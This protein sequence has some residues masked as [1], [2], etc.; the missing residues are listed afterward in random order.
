MHSSAL[1]ESFREAIES[2]CEK[3]SNLLTTF[4]SDFLQDRAAAYAEVIEARGA[5]LD[6]CVGFIDRTKVQICRPGGPPV[7]QRSVSS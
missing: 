7:T 5:T 6:K 4:R 2:L 3:R 1:T